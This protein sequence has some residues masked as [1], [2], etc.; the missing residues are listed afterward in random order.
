MFYFTEKGRKWPEIKPGDKL[1]YTPRKAPGSM[2]LKISMFPC[3]V[4]QIWIQLYITS[5]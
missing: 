2:K 4:F 1:G 3:F 5:V